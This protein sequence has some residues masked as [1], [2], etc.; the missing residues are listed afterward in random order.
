M[1]KITID[2]KEYESDD[3]SEEVK[4]IINSLS[5]LKN[6]T[7]RLN[8]QLAAYKTAEAAYLKA[9]KEKID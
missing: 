3:L 1:A 2:G 9:L 4:N 8:G 5:F 7:V 6:E